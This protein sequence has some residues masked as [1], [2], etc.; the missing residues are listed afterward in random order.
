MFEIVIRFLGGLLSMYAFTHDE[1]YHISFKH[2]NTFIGCIHNNCG[3]STRI[4]ML[5]TICKRNRLQ[6]N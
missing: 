2:I 3:S 1:V 5:V 4:K 6:L